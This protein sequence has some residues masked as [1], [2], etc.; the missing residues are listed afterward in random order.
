M[1]P[2]RPPLLDVRD[3][4]VHLRV[5][6]HIVKAVDGVD[7]TVGPASASA[8]WANRARARARWRGR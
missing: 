5:G 4:K 8:S 1:S 3:L 6:G 7:L 2:A